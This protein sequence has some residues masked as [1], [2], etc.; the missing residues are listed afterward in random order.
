MTIIPVLLYHSVTADP[1]GWIAPYA[2]T[3]S[4]FARHVDIILGS[5]RTAMTVTELS[6]A[7]SG[8]LPLPAR[9]VVITFDDGFADFFGAAELFA[10]NGLPSTL[11][12]CTGVLRGRGPRSADQRLP[13]ADMLDW[14]QLRELS[15]L[16]VEVGAHTH[17]HP[18]LDI[19]RTAAATD[20]VRRSKEL[21][22][23]VLGAEVPSFAYP[24]GFNSRGTRRIAAAAGYSSAV[25][26]MNAHCCEADDA[27]ALPRLTVHTTTSTARLAYWLSGRGVRPSAHPERMRTKAWR[28]YRRA[29]GARSTRGVFTQTRDAR[30]ERSALGTDHTTERQD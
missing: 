28:V 23:D 20:E 30:D 25:A 5:G 6:A 21:L 19:V 1:P 14:S 3:P 13:Q 10:R 9:P 15:E 17:N 12:A 2:V 4:T 22:E 18:Q 8:H 24:H 11:Y 27:F 16:G 26:V 7:L 29:R